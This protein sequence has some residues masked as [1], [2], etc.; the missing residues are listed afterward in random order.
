M[1]TPILLDLPTPTP[2]PADAAHDHILTQ[3][4]PSRVRRIH[5]L[6]VAGTG[7]GSFA[8]L[9]KDAGFVVTGS[10]ENVYPPM[11]DM[12]KAWGIAAMSPYQEANLEAAQPDLVVVGIGGSALG[13]ELAAAAL[14]TPGDAMRTWFLDNTD[15]DGIALSSGKVG[16]F[17]AIIIVIVAILEL[18]ALGLMPWKTEANKGLNKLYDGKGVKNPIISA[19]GLLVITVVLSELLLK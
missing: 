8:G 5:V 18:N 3:L 16:A 7:M 17:W 19:T 13:P 4:D 1:T 15:P 2:R 14:G 10:D 6:G 11:S 9:L 12:L